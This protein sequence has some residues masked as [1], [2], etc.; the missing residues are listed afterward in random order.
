MNVIDILIGI[1]LNM[2]V[3]VGSIAIFIM[4]ILPIHD[5]GK[6]LLLLKSSSISFF[7]G[8]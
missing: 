1:A 2:K 3:A 5:H 4:L 7:R 6:S 8:L